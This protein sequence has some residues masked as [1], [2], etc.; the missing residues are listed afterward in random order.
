MSILKTLKALV[1]YQTQL[2]FSTIFSAI[3]AMNT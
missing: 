3:K 2:G 1:V